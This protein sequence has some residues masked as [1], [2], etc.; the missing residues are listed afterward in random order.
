MQLF[1]LLFMKDYVED[2]I[3]CNINANIV[4]SRVTYGEFLRWIG[5]WFLM[6]TVIGP[7]RE[8]FFSLKPI[9]PFLGAPFRVNEYMSKKR[10][11]KILAAIRYNDTAPPAYKDQFWVVRELIHTWNL[12]M[13]EQFG[14][15][16][17]NCLDESMSPWTSKYT[18][19]GHVFLPRKP[20][21]L[22]NEYHSICCCQSGIMYAV[23]IVE[24][25]DCS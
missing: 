22:G 19:P 8:A 16:W 10:F 25:K 6:A 2:V 14:P 13:S 23:E 3:L 24:G 11:E 5:I 12:N 7:R 18:C 21:P 1:E 20:W 17:V 4:G 9:D 15:G